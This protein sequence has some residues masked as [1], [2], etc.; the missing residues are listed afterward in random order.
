MAAVEEKDLVTIKPLGAS[1]AF[2][3][4]YL[5]EDRNTKKQYALK[6]IDKLFLED[7]QLVQIANETRIVLSVD[8]PHIVKSHYVFE[9]RNEINIYM[10]LYPGGDVHGYFDKF[11]SL[12]ECN[13]YIIFRQLASA[14]NY[15]HNE[16]HIVHRDIKLEN[17]LF[18]NQEDLNVV[19]TD[20]G[21]SIHRDPNGPLLNDFPGSPMYAAPELFLGQPY[22]G[23]PSDIWAMGISLYVLSTGYYPFNSEDKRVL[24]NKVIN[25]LPITKDIEN[26][27]LVDLIN[28]ML[29][30]SPDRRITIKEV[31]E[32][33]WMV[34]WH[35]KI[36]NGHV[37]EPNV[38]KNLIVEDKEE[39]LIYPDSAAMDDFL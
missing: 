17:L 18:D 11:Y 16:K 6:K 15:L 19:L 37:C 2:G 29:R 34:S 7:W 28:K 20:F 38:S 1:G 23:Y 31:L 27:E 33:P 36:K 22:A 8:H 35:N 3:E 30:K 26:P 12:S 24:V 4:I 39:M 32:H 13:V 9:S 21:F 5:A 25:T 14:I 10:D